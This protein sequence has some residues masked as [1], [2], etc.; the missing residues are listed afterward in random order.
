MKKLVLDVD[1]LAVDSF[2]TAPEPGTPRGTV[3][4]RELLNTPWCVTTPC[5]TQ[6]VTGCNTQSTLPNC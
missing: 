4:A 3:A 2:P 6:P 5:P 1:S